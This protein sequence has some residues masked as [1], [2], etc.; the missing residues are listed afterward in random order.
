M[1]DPRI[2]KSSRRE[3]F[4]VAGG[5]RYRKNYRFAWLR[6]AVRLVEDSDLD[7][8]V[9]SADSLLRVICVVNDE[10]RSLVMEESL[11]KRKREK[12]FFCIQQ[13]DEDCRGKCQKRIEN[14]IHLKGN[15]RN[16]ATT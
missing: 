15:Y 14:T 10:S 2:E 6:L 3:R 4:D 12:N 16:K 5:A 7:P 8:V 13:R 9:K 11:G 1:I